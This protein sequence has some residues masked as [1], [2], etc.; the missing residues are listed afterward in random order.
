MT[1]EEILPNVSK[2]AKNYKFGVADTLN[3][4]RELAEEI[5]K[6]RALVY[7]F[8]PALT[9]GRTFSNAPIVVDEDQLAQMQK[10]ATGNFF[11]IY[12]IFRV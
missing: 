6:R 11:F 9:T 1:E 8:Q 7:T 10:G 3:F 5:I 12:F 4:L 2:A